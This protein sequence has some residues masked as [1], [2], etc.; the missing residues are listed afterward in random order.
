M[1]GLFSMIY[2]VWFSCRKK[3][4]IS[5]TQTIF[6]VPWGFV[7]GFYC[8]IKMQKNG[9]MKNSELNQSNTIVSIEFQ[10]TTSVLVMLEMWEKR[11][12]AGENFQMQETLAECGAIDLTQLAIYLFI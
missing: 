11:F 1:K 4:T 12:Y 7:S 6:L 10:L 9:L 2:V 8:I 3:E 5:I